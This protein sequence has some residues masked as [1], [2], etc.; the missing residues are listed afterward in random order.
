MALPLIT[1]GVDVGTGARFTFIPERIKNATLSNC[2]LLHVV[3]ANVLHNRM[4]LS[5]S[6]DG[7]CTL[8]SVVMQRVCDIIHLDWN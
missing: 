5:W 2:M 1:A 6:N 8:R 3:C 4:M 7:A